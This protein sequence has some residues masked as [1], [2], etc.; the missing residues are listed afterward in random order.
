VTVSDDPVDLSAAYLRAIKLGESVERYEDNL[1][2]FDSADLAATLDTD[3]TRLAFWL[4]VYNAA[5]QRA[6]D[7]DPG[8]YESRNAFFSKPLVTVAGTDLSLDDIEHGILR[9]SYPKW[10]M[11]YLRWPFPDD[12]AARHGLRER[13]PRIHFALNCGAESCPAIAAY[14]REE[15]DTQLD[16]ATEGYLN[17]EVEYDPET[18]R[19]LVPRMMLWFRGDF[20]GKRGILDMLEQYEQLPPG[21]KPRLSYREW[22]WSLEPRAFAEDQ[23]A[24]GD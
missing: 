12:F 18:G 23:P 5:T 2:A 3:E 6:L 1:A 9:R 8:Q 4:N 10:T 21:A 24:A 16:R 19:A 7:A 20:G 17:S 22:D 15:I 14:T 13:D 11:G